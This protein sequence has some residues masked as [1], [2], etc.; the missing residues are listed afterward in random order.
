M[1]MGTVALGGIAIG[2]ALFVM[3]YL[4]ASR[5]EKALTEAKKYVSGVNRQIAQI[6]TIGEYLKR[7]DKRI[8]E[9]SSIL[10]KLDGKARKS[11]SEIESIKFEIE[12]D[13]HLSKLSILLQIVTSLSEVMK[14]PIL[15]L[16]GKLTFESEAISKKYKKV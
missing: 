4:Y 3:G 1:A 5:S 8:D 15:D 16:D 9:L 7:V 6:E 2:P 12:N 11:L 13:D 14:V 10:E